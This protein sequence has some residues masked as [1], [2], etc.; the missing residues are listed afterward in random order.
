MIE[1]LRSTSIV[2]F[3]YAALV[4]SVLAAIYTVTAAPI[5]SLVDEAVLVESI[6]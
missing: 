4:V 5:P 3:A 1:Y 6:D 2:S